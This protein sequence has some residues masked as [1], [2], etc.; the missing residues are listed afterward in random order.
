MTAKQIKKQNWLKSLDKHLKKT[1]RE[2]D[3]TTGFEQLY[4]YDLR[5]DEDFENYVELTDDHDWEFLDEDNHPCQ[6]FTRWHFKAREEN[7]DDNGYLVK[8][9]SNCNEHTI[10]VRD[11][12][13]VRVCKE[14]DF[15]FVSKTYHK[16]EQKVAAWREFYRRERIRESALRKSNRK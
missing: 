6:I 2:P 3:L 10:H 5:T 9:C 16:D 8:F 4:L 7:R 12:R 11:D 14:C 15:S 1:F 13:C